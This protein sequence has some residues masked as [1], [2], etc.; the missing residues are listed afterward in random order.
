MG[1]I[2][3]TDD[4]HNY[5]LNKINEGYDIGIVEGELIPLELRTTSKEEKTETLKNLIS[6]ILDSTAK[7]YGYDSIA[8]AVSYAE[9]PS[10][11]QY[12]IEGQAFRL[13]R[14]LVWEKCNQTLSDFEAGNITEPSSEDVISQL[15]ILAL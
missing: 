9:E 10:V 11:P 6:G 2:P 5:F 14:S 8:S 4:K 12:Q 13:W 1:A 3:I 7:R 15:P